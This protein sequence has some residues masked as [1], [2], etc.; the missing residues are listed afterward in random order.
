MNR[1]AASSD[2]ASPFST[3]PDPGTKPA[4]YQPQNK[5]RILCVFPRYS[6]SFGTFHHAY[7]LRHGLRACMPPQGILVIAAYLPE[8]WEVRL[9]DENIK[10]ATD[11]DYRWADAVLVSG[12]HIQRNAMNQINE[13]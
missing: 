5:R 1:M 8:Q 12:M 2:I 9:I 10:P 6:R 11:A 4:A 3:L 7:K 13:R